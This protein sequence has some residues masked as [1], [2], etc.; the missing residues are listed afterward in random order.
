M[1]TTDVTDSIAAK[2]A[3]ITRL[4]GVIKQITHC[5][6]ELQRE[7]LRQRDRIAE[8][9]KLT[10]LQKETIDAQGKALREARFTEDCR[11]YGLIKCLVAR[12]GY[13]CGEVDHILEY[14]NGLG[15]QSAQKE[16]ELVICEGA[17]D[18]QSIGSSLCDPCRHGRLHKKDEDCCSL[19]CRIDSK[20]V[21][22]IPVNPL[23]PKPSPVPTSGTGTAP[24]ATTGLREWVSDSL[25]RHI[26]LIEACQNRLDKLEEHMPP[27]MAKDIGDLT[28]RMD[29]LESRLALEGKAQQEQNAAIS[30]HAEQIYSLESETRHLNARLHEIEQRQGRDRAKIMEIICDLRKRVEK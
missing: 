23:V 6:C 12:E 2:D 29:N 21:K 30:K 25:Q 4:N 19:G 22:C 13:D 5:H 17:L 10:A 24:G 14:L 27:S 18:M 7:M 11:I 9:E 1:K 8:L 16:P 15:Q 28:L 26:R 20:R 3:E